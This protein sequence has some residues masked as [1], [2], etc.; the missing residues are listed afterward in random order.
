MIVPEACDGA[1]IWQTYSA[2]KAPLRTRLR[3]RRKGTEGPPGVTAT[4]RLDR[5]TKNLATRLCPGDIA[6]IDHADLDLT[7]A[8]ALIGR[9]VAAVVNAACSI[10]GRYPNRGPQ[11]LVEAGIPLIDDVGPEVFDRVQEGQ[12]VRLDGDTLYAGEQVVAK[13]RQQDAA[14]VAAAMAEAKTNVASEIQAFAAN[15]LDYITREY[16][17]LIDGIG[18]PA[19]RTNLDGRDVLVV[20]RGYHYREDIAALRSFIRERRPAMVGVDGGADVLM[21]AGYRPEIIVGDMD[22]VSDKALLSGAEVVLHTYP[23]GRSPRLPR[24]QALGL[25]PVLCPAAGTSEDVALLLADEKGASLIVV[26]GMHRSLSEFLDK[27]RPGM[28]STFLTRLRVDDKIVDAKGVSRLYQ[29][30]VSAASLIPLVLAAA[31]T[32]VVVLAVTTTG[33]IFFRNLGTE[34]GTFWYWLTGLF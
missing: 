10:T 19:L 21:E 7:G 12:R 6:I 15:T 33:H 22:S 3:I 17:L 4:A 34:L 20:G 11:L 25:D 32:L 1:Q 9:Q 31:V 24:L 18:V 23:D 14:T 13:G 30:R 5:R 26:V 16:P 2:M 8:D 29:S 27:G 28:A